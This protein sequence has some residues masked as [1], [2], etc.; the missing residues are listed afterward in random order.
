MFARGTT[1]KEKSDTCFSYSRSLFHRRASDSTRWFAQVCAYMSSL[2]NWDRFSEYELRNRNQWF[3]CSSLSCGDV[4]IHKNTSPPSVPPAEGSS[5]TQYAHISNNIGKTV[6]F[7][8]VSR[9]SVILFM[10]RKWKTH[11]K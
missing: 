8:F 9:I 2:M 3:L 4:L 7:Y 5:R 1:S 11:T 10:I 6:N